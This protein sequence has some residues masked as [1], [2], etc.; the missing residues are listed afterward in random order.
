M[1]K[2][3]DFLRSEQS[4]DK[5]PDRLMAGSAASEELRGSAKANKSAYPQDRQAARSGKVEN[6]HNKM[7]EQRP[8]QRNE[9]RRTPESRHERMEPRGG[10]NQV[11][12][13]KGK[14]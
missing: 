14:A 5:H 12:A 4:R 6:D 13:R 9:G 2:K 10:H 8:T 11:S 3:K 1:S 7:G